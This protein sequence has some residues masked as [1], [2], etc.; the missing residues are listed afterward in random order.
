V[1]TTEE[2]KA[3]VTD[4]VA[5]AVRG[6]VSSSPDVQADAYAEIAGKV[7]ELDSPARVVTVEIRDQYGRQVT[8]PADDTARL[9]AKLAGTTTL[10]PAALA[11]IRELG[12][13]IRETCEHKTG[14]R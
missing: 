3:D 11:V 9:F 1:T 14:G 8:H 13:D 2:F 5:S 12:Y 4:I 6:I 7:A 10:T